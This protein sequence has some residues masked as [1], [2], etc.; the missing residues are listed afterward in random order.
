MWDRMRCLFTDLVFDS[1][2]E[3]FEALLVGIVKQKPILIDD[4]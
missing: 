4:S 2:R 3:L 1:M